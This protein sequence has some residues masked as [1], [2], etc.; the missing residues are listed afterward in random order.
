MIVNFSEE[1]IFT[2]KKGLC[3]DQTES[4]RRGRRPRRRCRGDESVSRIGPCEQL[5]IGTHVVLCLLH[6]TLIKYIQT[7]IW[8]I[9]YLFEN[10]CVFL[11][12]IR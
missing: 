7:L 8:E 12:H 6:L 4:Q 1:K 3:Q 2:S 5:R 11:L 10:I 9:Q